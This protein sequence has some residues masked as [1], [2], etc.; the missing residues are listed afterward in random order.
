MLNASLRNTFCPNNFEKPGIRNEAFCVTTLRL[1]AFFRNM[2]YPNN[3]EK[4]E[5]RICLLR[6]AFSVFYISF[7]KFTQ[8]P[9]EPLCY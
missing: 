9:K 8:K 6:L 2:V 7:K 4:P 5:I 3:F 1:N